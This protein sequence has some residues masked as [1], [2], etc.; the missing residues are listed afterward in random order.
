MIRLSPNGRKKNWFYDY[1][2]AFAEN[3]QYILAEEKYDQLLS[4]Y[5]GIV[6]EYLIMQILSSVYLGNILR[7][8]LC[9]FTALYLF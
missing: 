8:K 6:R 5:E 9:L 2:E 1:A 7:L 4:Y 3:K